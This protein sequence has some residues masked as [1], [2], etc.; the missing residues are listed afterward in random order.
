MTVDAPIHPPQSTGDTPPVDNGAAAGGKARSAPLRGAG[1]RVLVLVGPVVL[2]GVWWL[3]AQLDLVSDKLLPGPV[4]SLQAVYE[5]ATSGT[6]L[7]DLWSTVYR[8]LAALF[9]ATAIGVPLGILLGA[10]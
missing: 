6:L 8:M 3:A 1:R 2:L 10:S 9:F 7:L 4:E 5:A